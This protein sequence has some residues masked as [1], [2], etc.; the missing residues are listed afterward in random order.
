MNDE[1][2]QVLQM[3]ASGQVTAEEGGFLL[4]ALDHDG[5]PAAGGDAVAAQGRPRYLRVMVT[6]HGEHGK[7]VNVRVPIQLLRAGVKLGTMLPDQ[8]KDKVNDALRQKGAAFDISGLKAEDLDLLLEHL[9]DLTVDVE[10][11]KSSTV[12]FSVER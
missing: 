7:K 12:R 6:E 2:M 4:A 3:V 9:D 11:D 5:A 10:G 1:R 8:A